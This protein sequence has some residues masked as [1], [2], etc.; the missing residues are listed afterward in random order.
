MGTLGR[1]GAA[2]CDPVE[3]RRGATDRQPREG[4]LRQPIRQRRLLRIHHQGPLVIIS[5]FNKNIL[6]EPWES[7]RERRTEGDPSIERETPGDIQ[8]Q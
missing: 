8:D 4:V 5:T 2:G 1:S 3:L 7:L 6:R